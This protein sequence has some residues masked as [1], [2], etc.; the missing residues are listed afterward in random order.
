MLVRVGCEF[1]YEIAFAT[2]SV[3]QIQPRPDGEHRL[4]REHWEATPE[5]AVHEYHDMYGNICRRLTMPPGSWR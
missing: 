4:L 1:Q 2:P 5:V 3:L